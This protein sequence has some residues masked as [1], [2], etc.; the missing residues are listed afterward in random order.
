M[1]LYDRSLIAGKAV[2]SFNNY[3][4]SFVVEEKRQWNQQSVDKLSHSP[5]TTKVIDVFGEEGELICD[6]L[7]CNHKFSVHGLGTSVCQCRHP[8]NTRVGV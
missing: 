1:E 4:Q 6:Y 8:H 7:R 3:S 2:H 5:T